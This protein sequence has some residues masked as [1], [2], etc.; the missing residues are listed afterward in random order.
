M[1]LPARTHHCHIAVAGA[2]AGP[3]MGTIPPAGTAGGTW[4]VHCAP[5]RA[6]IVPCTTGLW[7]IVNVNVPPLM[8]TLLQ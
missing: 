1:D 4:T 8:I 6:V 7:G 2:Q 5:L 3:P